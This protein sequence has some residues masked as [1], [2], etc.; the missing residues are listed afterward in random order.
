M[1]GPDWEAE[2][3]EL[4]E[5][6]VRDLGIPGVGVGVVHGEDRVFANAGVTNVEDPLP[7]TSSTRFQAGSISKTVTSA[8]VMVLVEGGSLRLDSKVGDLIGDLVPGLDL[9]EVTVEHLLSHQLGIDG[10]HIFTHRAEGGLASLAQ[11]RRLF[12]PGTGFSY[13]NAGFSLAGAVIEAVSGR[14]FGDFVTAEFLE[15]LGMSASCYTSDRAITHRVA[16]PHASIGDETFL[17][18]DFGWQPGWE[19]LPVDWPAAGLVS[20]TEDLVRWCEAQW[21]TVLSEQS[22]E[23]LHQP[24]IDADA[25][26]DV[27]LDWYVHDVAG[28]RSISH[29]GVT[30]GYV[31]ELLAVPALRFGLVVLTNSANGDVAI[32]EIRRWVLKRVLG[33]RDSPLGADSGVDAATVDAAYGGRYLHSFADL[34]FGRA[35]D[36]TLTIAEHP[37]ADGDGLWLPPADGVPLEL[38]LIDSNN[39]V[40]VEAVGS[41]RLLR[42]GTDQNGVDWLQW[43]GRRALR[44]D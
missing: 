44:A 25:A 6:T 21:G 31:S 43:R 27:A 7:V 17:L 42:W 13:S 41:P 19:Q 20:T 24:I 14:P 26:D 11:A 29:G 30:V 3:A 18:R 39:A 15:P 37:R 8:A 22:L 9:S 36:G 32:H 40:A 4:V 10:D 1:A 12:D 16:A 23:R 2:L 35:A 34:E 38:R 33:H 5:S 28:H